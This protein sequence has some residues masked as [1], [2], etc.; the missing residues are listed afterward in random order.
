VQPVKIKTTIIILLAICLLLV[1]L[2]LTPIVTFTV[3]SIATQ[4]LSQSIALRRV[5]RR[6]SRDI[7]Y[8]Y[9]NERFLIEPICDVRR[10]QNLTTSINRT[11]IDVT[12]DAHK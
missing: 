9:I 11:I 7:Q 6:K 8:T 12:E 2:K 10:S 1:L 5:R 4:A 3:S